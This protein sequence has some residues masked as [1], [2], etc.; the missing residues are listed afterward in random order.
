MSTLAVVHEVKVPTSLKQVGVRRDYQM[1]NPRD[2]DIE[3]SFNPRNYSLPENREHIDKLKRSIS[4]IGLIQPLIVRFNRE[5]G[6]ATVVDGESRL[7]SI[8]EL[9]AEGHSV[10]S[11]A[12]IP[13]FPAPQGSNDESSRLLAAITSNT[14]KP[15]SKW[16]LGTAFQRLFNFGLSPEKIAGRT[17]YTERFIG[18]AIELADAPEE[19]KILLSAAAVTPSLALATLRTNGSEAT[20]ILKAR[21]EV[22]KVNGQKTAKR[23]KAPAP[24]AAKEETKNVSN[25][26]LYA[27]EEMAKAIDVWIE[28]ATAEAEAK[29]IE[30]HKAYRKLIRAPKR[31]EAA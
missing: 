18:E 16:E 28:D 17:G 10:L 12:D 21:V 27:A 13:C 22:A 5:T 15:L 24:K 3:E 6:R 19:I 14:G 29:L 2:I 23:D 9:I 25:L 11:E 20:A 1:I 4:E 30:A 31:E 26:V 8:M 7:R